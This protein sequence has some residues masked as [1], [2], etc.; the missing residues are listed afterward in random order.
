MSK[1]E[2]E[3]FQSDQSLLSHTVTRRRYAD[4]VFCARNEPTT[5]ITHF[6][7]FRNSLYPTIEFTVEVGGEKINFLDLTI[8]LVGVATSTV[9]T[10]SP[11]PPTSPSTAHRSTPSLTSW[12]LTTITS[13]GWFQSL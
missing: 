11:P 12:P 9:S 3:L 13:I 10:E 4:D 6:L 5:L 8:S 1:F 7:N 2:S